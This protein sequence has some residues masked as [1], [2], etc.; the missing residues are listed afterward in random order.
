M[1]MIHEGR[2]KINENTELGLCP[3]QLPDA[4]SSAKGFMADTAI[5]TK[6]CSLVY[7]HDVFTMQHA[8]L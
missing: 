5:Y 1:H 8:I 6:S 7:K 3:E 4:F 2:S